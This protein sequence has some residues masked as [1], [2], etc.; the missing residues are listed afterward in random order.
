PTTAPPPA[1]PHL[2]P[3]TSRPTPPLHDALPIW[4]ARHPAPPRQR[5]GPRL[6][7][8]RRDGLNSERL[9]QP[10]ADKLTSWRRN[11]LRSRAGRSRS[12]RKS[13]SELQSPDHLVCRLLLE[14]K[15]PHTPS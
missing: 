14:K 9:G 8:L 15:N 10:A 6:F 3:P 2:P 7:R 13:T 1:P 5:R 12:D 4:R 11:F